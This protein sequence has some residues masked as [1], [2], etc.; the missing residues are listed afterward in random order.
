M[1]FFVADAEGNRSKKRQ[2]RQ[3]DRHERSRRLMEM[4]DGGSATDLDFRWTVWCRS[5]VNQRWYR[6]IG[7]IDENY[8][9]CLSCIDSTPGLWY[10]FSAMQKAEKKPLKIH[11]IC[12]LL[13]LSLFLA[14]GRDCLVLFCCWRLYALVH[15]I[16]LLCYTFW[17]VRYHMS[18]VVRGMCTLYVYVFVE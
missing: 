7:G 1:I 18:R 9:K 12:L 3:T 11:L 10:L 17:V 14:L 5:V 4:K 2:M 16:F 13:F 8:L 15:T 6:L